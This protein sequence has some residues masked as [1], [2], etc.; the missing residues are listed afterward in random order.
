LVLL[1][2][3][4]LAVTEL[5]LVPHLAVCRAGWEQA[6]AS[7]ERCLAQ[8]LLQLPAMPLL[9]QL[10]QGCLLACTMAHL[11]CWV[12]EGRQVLLMAS[13]RQHWGILLVLLVVP[14]LVCSL[15]LVSV[16]CCQVDCWLKEG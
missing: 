10:A 11:V 12:L 15:Q 1:L 9:Q 7:W 3:A 8:Q 5:L 14:T 13:W 4:Q 2:V 6:S 16:P